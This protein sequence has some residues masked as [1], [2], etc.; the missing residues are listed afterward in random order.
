MKA[1]AAS[2]LDDTAGRVSRSENMRRIHGKNTVPELTVRRLLYRLGYRYRLHRSDLPGKPDIV[3][4]KRRKVIF[5]HG[6]FWHAHSCRK[7]HQP[8][9]NQSYWTPKLERNVERDLKN[10]AALSSLGWESLVVWECQT[11][12]PFSE[13]ERVLNEFLTSHHAD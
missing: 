9:T 12:P 1:A 8:Q 4:A 3:F 5:V 6:C 11:A 2:K 13:L 10:E 7:A